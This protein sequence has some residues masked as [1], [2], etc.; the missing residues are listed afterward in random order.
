MDQPEEIVQA[1]VAWLLQRPG[2]W[3][4][5]QRKLSRRRWPGRCRGQ[6]VD[7]AGGGQWRGWAVDQASGEARQEVSQQ[8]T[9]VPVC[10]LL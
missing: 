8:A 9:V 1:G 7:Q 3:W 5:C 6:P 4:P 2:R 10:R